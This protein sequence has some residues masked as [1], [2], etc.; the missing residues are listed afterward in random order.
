MVSSGG[1][2]AMFIRDNLPKLQ[3]N[4][5]ECISSF[6]IL[7]KHTLREKV[8]NS[9]QK[10]PNSAPPYFEPRELHGGNRLPLLTVNIGGSLRRF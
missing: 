8:R 2:D 7:H 1:V 3:A 6:K 9:N 5:I 10:M 4:D